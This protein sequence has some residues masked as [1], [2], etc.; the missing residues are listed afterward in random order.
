MGDRAYQPNARPGKLAEPLRLACYRMISDQ[1]KQSR[2]LQGTFKGAE[3]I[4]GSWYFPGMP[5]KWKNASVDYYDNQTISLA[6]LEDYIARRRV[7]AL[8]EKSRR[9]DGAIVYRSPVCNDFA[10]LKVDGINV[11]AAARGRKLHKV[12]KRDLPKGIQDTPVFR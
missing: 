3:L 8:R 2:G 10:T 11:P 1:S 7:F 6:E 5:A 4:D 12:F 9:A